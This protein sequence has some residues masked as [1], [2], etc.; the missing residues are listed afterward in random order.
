MSSFDHLS[1]VFSYGVLYNVH[2]Y[3]AL[4]E[5]TRRY[6]EGLVDQDAVMYL[7]SSQYVTRTFALYVMSAKNC[8]PRAAALKS[9]R[10]G[11]SEMDGRASRSQ[12]AT[13][14]LC[15]RRLDTKVLVL[16][17]LLMQRIAHIRL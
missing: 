12:H 17:A 8:G 13:S 14:G 7:C 10:G 1:N 16:G 3:C 2:M 6:S 4:L 9:E 15:H 11:R 5:A